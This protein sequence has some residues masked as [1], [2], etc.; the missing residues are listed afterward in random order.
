MNQTL[1][2][3]VFAVSDLAGSEHCTNTTDTETVGHV[4]SKVLKKKVKFSSLVKFT[5]HYTSILKYDPKETYF[6]LT[7]CDL[8]MSN[9]EMTLKGKGGFYLDQ[10]IEMMSNSCGPSLL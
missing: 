1:V 4:R 5:A 2:L 3:W 10:G 6:F 8:H 9:W 7:F